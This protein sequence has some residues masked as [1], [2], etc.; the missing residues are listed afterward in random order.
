MLRT[1]CVLSI[2]T[3]D[4]TRPFV[5][6]LSSS[7]CGRQSRYSKRECLNGAFVDE[8]ESERSKTDRIIEEVRSSQTKVVDPMQ[9]NQLLKFYPLFYVE[10]K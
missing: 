5:R 6:F 4:S 9:L 2:L 7:W 8:H 1:F 10:E 3:L